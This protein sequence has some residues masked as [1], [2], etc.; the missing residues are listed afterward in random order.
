MTLTE[1]MK[2]RLLEKVNEVFDGNG[3]Q[4]FA[5]RM[6]D[7]MNERNVPNV[8][9]GLQNFPKEKAGHVHV[10]MS[11]IEGRITTPNYGHI[12]SC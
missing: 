2:N 5:D 1:E 4:D 10:E 9:E 7:L 8:Y 12:E 11:N 6:L 3:E